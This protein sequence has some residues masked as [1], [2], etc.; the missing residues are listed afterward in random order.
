MEQTA[1]RSPKLL[2]ITD[3]AGNIHYGCDQEWFGSSWQRMSGCG[4]CVASNIFL[5]LLRQ[6][7]LAFPF[8]I[9]GKADFIRF[10]DEVWRYIT[11]TQNGIYRSDQWIEGGGGI[12]ESARRRLCLPAAGYPQGEN[13]T[14]V[15]FPFYGVYRRRTS[16]RLSRG[17][18]ESFQWK[19]SKSGRVALGDDR[20]PAK[21]RRNPRRYLRRR[22][23][24]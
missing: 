4:P 3:G 20:K 5:Y 6:K 18:F 16:F 8:E 22:R 23:Q 13:K 2:E 9:A 10:M 24:A 1:L 21:G 17:F 19:A 14:P 15:L 12:P 11:P 7:K